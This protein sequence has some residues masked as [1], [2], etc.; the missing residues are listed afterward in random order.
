[1]CGEVGEASVKQGPFRGS[2]TVSRDFYR[3]LG[4]SPHICKIKLSH[5]LISISAS[6]LNGS[7]V[8]HLVLPLGG[9]V[10]AGSGFFGL[11]K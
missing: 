9:A 2:P 5:P 8:Q 7:T 10:Y 3:L 1:M 4:D 6:G 11:I